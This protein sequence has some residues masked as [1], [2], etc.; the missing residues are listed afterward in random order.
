MTDKFYLDS[1]KLIDENKFNEF[2]DKCNSHSKYNQMPIALKSLIQSIILEKGLLKNKDVTNGI[3]ILSPDCLALT[4]K[5]VSKDLKKNFEKGLAIVNRTNPN[6]IEKMWDNVLYS[7]FRHDMKNVEITL[8]GD[9]KVLGRSEEAKQ[10]SRSFIVLLHQSRRIKFIMNVSSS[11]VNITIEQNFD[12]IIPITNVETELRATKQY[13]GHVGIDRFT[14]PIKFYLR[15][16]YNL[17][18]A[19]NQAIFKINEYNLEHRTDEKAVSPPTDEELIKIV[20]NLVKYIKGHYDIYN[21]PLY[22]FNEIA[23]EVSRLGKVELMPKVRTN[24]TNIEKLAKEIS[25]VTNM[26]FDEAY[27]MLVMNSTD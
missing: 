1:Q 8:N 12:R 21:I 18:D 25:K 14:S 5:S 6:D 20:N 10:I 3:E 23:Q 26:T 19:I 24:T 15:S 7:V 11:P 17:H 27:T 9:I 4:I 16:K 13:F 22:D 2:I